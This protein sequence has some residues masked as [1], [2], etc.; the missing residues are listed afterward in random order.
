MGVFFMKLIILKAIKNWIITRFGT[1]KWDK[2]AHETGLNPDEFREQDTYFSKDRFT[3]LVENVSGFTKLSIKDINE[4][5]VHYW[6]T[7]F[8][9][10]VYHFI[11]Q[12]SNNAKQFILS[13]FK[14]NNDICNQFP[15]KMIHAIDYQT[16]DDNTISAVY[17]KEQ[18]LVDIISVLRGSAHFFSDKFNIT[19]LN[20][21]SV[22]IVFEKSELV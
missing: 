7:D 12:R 2:I 16:I 21:N 9:P 10:K 5:F 18:S 19:K 22:S 8:A 15:N 6:M 11:I 3:K 1:V 20:N 17:P 14:L 13:V 4:E